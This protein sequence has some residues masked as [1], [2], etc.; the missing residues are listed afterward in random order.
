MLVNIWFRFY[1]G[2]KSQLAHYLNIN[3]NNYEVITY[4]GISLG[5]HDKYIVVGTQVFIAIEH[6]WVVVIWIVGYQCSTMQV[7]R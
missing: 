4:T 7:G 3:T 1:P 5:K 2:S 6:F